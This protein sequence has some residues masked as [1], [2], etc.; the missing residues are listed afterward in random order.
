MIITNTTNHT[1]TE[2]NNNEFR[3]TSAAVNNDNYCCQLSPSPLLSE[4]NCIF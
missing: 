4:L 2:I 3:G 1:T